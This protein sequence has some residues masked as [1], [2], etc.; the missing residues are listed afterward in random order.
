M[1]FHIFLVVHDF[2]LYHPLHLLIAYYY[3]SFPKFHVFFIFFSS[4][5]PTPSFF[6]IVFNPKPK[7]IPRHF[8]VHLNFHFFPCSTVRL[9]PGWMKRSS[10]W[11]DDGSSGQSQE[12]LHLHPQKYTGVESGVA[13]PK[14]F[15]DRL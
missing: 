2:P 9:W 10:G 8:F 11:M 3:I 12:L 1:S 14:A 6:F 4:F 13:S 7:S 5:L 15:I